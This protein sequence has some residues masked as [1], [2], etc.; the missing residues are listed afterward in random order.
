[1]NQSNAGGVRVERVVRPG[2]HLWLKCAERVPRQRVAV[3][4]GWAGRKGVAFVGHRVGNSFYDP[5]TGEALLDPTHWMPLP[6]P[7]AA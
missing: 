7:P 1:M 4:L 3:L 5:S 2:N 6:E